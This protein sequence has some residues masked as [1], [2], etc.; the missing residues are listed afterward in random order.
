M[1]PNPHVSKYVWLFIGVTLGLFLIVPI[2]QL[3]ANSWLDNGQF[4]LTYYQQILGS[5]RFHTAFLNSLTVAAI[6]SLTATVLAFIL[7]YTIH[8][9][10]LPNGYKKFLGIMAQFPMLLPTITYGFAIIYTFGKKGLLTQLFG[11]QLI[12]NLYGF[13]GLWMGYTIYTLPIAFLLLNNTFFYLDK[14]TSLVSKLMGDNQ[15]RTFKTSVVVPLIETLAMAFIQCFFLSFTDYGI[16]AS[17][18]GRYEVIATQLYNELL[19]SSPSFGRGAVVAICMLIPSIISVILLSKLAKYRIKPNQTQP[20]DLP[21]NRVSDYCLGT[22]SGFIIL[23]VSSVFAVI[24]VAPFV[25]QWPYNLT[26]SISM[27]QSVLAST[28]LLQVYQNSIIVALLTALVGTIVSYT[29]AL[30]AERTQLWRNA[31]IASDGL[32]M[33]SNTT[34]GMV[35]GIAYLMLFSGTSI[36]NTLAIIVICNVVHYFAT[37][38]LMA[39]NALSK[40]NNGWELTAGLLGDSWIKSIFKVVLPNSFL[41]LLEIFSYYFIN[42]MVTVSAVIFI[43]GAQT[44]VLTSKVKE[45]E[46][47][48]RFNEIFI[49]SLMILLT[50]L[51][52]LAVIFGLRFYLKR[53]S[54][55][56]RRTKKVPVL[57]QSIIKQS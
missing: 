36:A 32:A 46:H 56:P 2:G 12:D 13:K 11:V 34:P 48:A 5:G 23:A 52:A 9:S 54:A 18:G 10:Q 30:I 51:A 14:K 41:T 8:W 31:K 45:L 7:A 19:G 6:S 16:P 47:Y 3:I 49:V 57:A 40:L 42:A 28:N 17:I 15:W 4:S 37:P 20:I 44:M 21:R 53:R 39:K 25:Q 22:L 26:P 55:S 43:A 29:L 1:Q 24:L 50:N 35:L 33:I 38:Y 27:L